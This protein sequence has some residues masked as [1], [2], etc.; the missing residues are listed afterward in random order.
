MAVAGILFMALA[1]RR[2]LPDRPLPAHEA[3]RRQRATLSDMYDL[4]QVAS[5]VYVKPG[6]SLAGQ[7]LADGGWGERLG[8]NVV[9]IS[10]GGNVHLA[11]PESEGVLAGDVVIFT[12]SMDEQEAAEHGLLFTADPA[13]RGRFIS[14]NISLAEAVLAPRSSL[15]GK[16]LKEINFRQNYNL[17]VLAIWREG[18]TLREA[19]AEL[20]LRF[21]DALL[22]QGPQA[23]I[24]QLRAGRDFLVLTEDVAGPVSPRKA[25]L[26]AGLTLA[27]LLLPAF[28]LLPIAEA[29]FSAATLMVL[30]GCL[31]MDEAYGSVEWKTV[32]LIA[33][34]LPLGLAMTDTGAAALIGDVLV[35]FVGGWGAVALV[36]GLY[37]LAT[38]LTQVMSG[39][40]TAVVLA[41]VAIAAAGRLGIDPRGLAIAVAMGCSSAFLTPFGH[42]TNVLVMGPGGYTTRDFARVGAPLTLVLFIVLLVVTPLV[43]HLR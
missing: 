42:A 16:T 17:T 39:Q 14:E 15:A 32:F 7:S 33:G 13:W 3:R 23:S 29:T 6:S 8:L 38:L 36:G 1:G 28:N 40:A 30:F 12:G 26:A 22:L 2:L 18:G 34:M 35:G 41:P 31:S 25:W 19:L 37:W 10:R 4:G 20:P 24:D 21:G 43:Y 11:P 5:E 9:G 27:G